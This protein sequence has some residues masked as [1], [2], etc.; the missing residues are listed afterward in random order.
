MTNSTVASFCRSCGKA[1]TDEEKAVPGTIQCSTCAPA[2]ARTAAAAAAAVAAPVAAVPGSGSPG[3]AFLLGL[4]PGVGAIYNGQYAKGLV[5]VFVFGLLLTLADSASHDS[6]HALLALMASGFYFY[7]PFEA[8]H[9]A[10]RQQMGLPVDEFSSLMPLKGHAGG[11]PVGPVLLIAIGVVFLLNN[12]NLL[13]LATLLRFWPV[14]LIALGLF[15]LR[16]RI[17]G[18]RHSH[19]GAGPFG[20]GGGSA[21]GGTGGGSGLNLGGTMVDDNPSQ[22]PFGGAGGADS[23]FVEARS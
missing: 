5:H 17:G 22:R 23:A 13:P 12:L 7:M 20:G 6:G 15:M 8:Y 9:T 4:I 16:D 18:G 3:L 2:G 14:G 21:S 1:L 11:H 19:S 10:R